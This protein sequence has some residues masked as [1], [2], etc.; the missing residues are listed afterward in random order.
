MTE[1]ITND[2]GVRTFSYGAWQIQRYDG[3]GSFQVM[4]NN[5][6]WDI[7]VYSGDTISFFGESQHGYEHCAERVYVPVII[8]R[9]IIRLID[10]RDR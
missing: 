5:K 1:W 3:D 6:D 9:E 4:C 8:L 7:D 2:H 10:E